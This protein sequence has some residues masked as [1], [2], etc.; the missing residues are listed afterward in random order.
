MAIVLVPFLI[1]G[2]F[3]KNKEKNDDQHIKI[4]GTDGIGL[5]TEVSSDYFNG[6]WQHLVK[7]EYTVNGVTYYKSRS[8]N[9][10]PFAIVGMKY[11]IKYIDEKPKKSIIFCNK[12]IV[13]EYKNIE[14]MRDSLRAI[15]NKKYEK[16]LKNAV[17]IETIKAWYPEHF[18]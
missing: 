11:M 7:Y 15:G 1:F 18:R 6:S 17:S 2:I 10:S 8:F 13:S 4:Y 12:P 9:H 5:V 3:I 16:G 14:R